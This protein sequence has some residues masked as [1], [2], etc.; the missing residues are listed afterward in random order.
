M[1]IRLRE[2][3]HFL[4]CAHR[5][6]LIEIDQAWAENYYVVK[7]NLLHER[8]HDPDKAYTLRGRELKLPP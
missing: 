8:V 1:Q 6:G 5:W 4:Y 7:G 2:I 3:Q